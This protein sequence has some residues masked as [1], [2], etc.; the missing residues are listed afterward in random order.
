MVKIIATSE[1]ATFLD[2]GYY[3]SR[4]GEFF[5]LR[6]SN[7]V[8]EY[9]GLL[10]A[11]DSDILGDWTPVSLSASEFR[12]AK[13]GA[14]YQYT[15]VVSG[16]G[17]APV[18]SLDDLIT[19]FESGLAS[20]TLSQISITGSKAALFVGDTVI[21][22][23]EFLTMDITPTGY[24]LT[25]GAQVIAVV[26]S[27]PTSL[28]QFSNLASIVDR[29]DVFWA[30]SNAE[31]NQIISDLSAYGVEEL[32][33]TSNGNELLSIAGSASE[34]SVTLMG[35]KIALKG[36]F[37]S[38]FGAA[39]PLI[40][41]I[42][43]FLDFGTPV[44]FSNMSGF[45]FDRLVITNLDGDVIL[46]T[47][48][49]LGNSDTLTLDLL[50]ID[51]V[52]VNQSLLQIGDN[53][54]NDRY[55]ANAPWLYELG[56]SLTG[57]GGRDHLF[58]LGGHDT[59]SGGNGKDYLFGGSGVDWLD[60]G[61]GDDVLNPGDNNQ[62]YDLV[63]GSKG[64]DT[65]IY[66]DNEKGY[67][68]LSY[69]ALNAGITASI[70]GVANIGTV[71]KGANGTDTIIDVVKPT[72]AWGFGI[73][74]TEYNDVFN[75]VGSNAA[76]EWDS[77]TGVRG[78]RGVD[79]YNLTLTNG[80]VVRVEFWDAATGINV[81]IGKGRIL[82]D[83]FGNAE[84]LNLVQNGG[85]LEIQATRFSD[86]LIGSSAD[87]RFILREGNDFANGGG[88]DDL[89]RYDRFGVDA[90]NVNLGTGTATGIWGGTAF[91]HTLKNFEDIR[92]SR[93]AND[94]LTG[95]KQGNEIDGRG[96]NDKLFGKA[97]RDILLG[98]DGNDMLKGG[99]YSDT[100]D[101]GTGDDLLYGGKGPDVF[102]FDAQVD[103]GVDSIFDFRNN[104]DVIRI[105]D[106]VFADL[107]ITGAGA[108]TLVAWETGQV[109]LEGVNSSL[110]EITDFD[111]V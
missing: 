99:S 14:G 65:V 94:K 67:Q 85:K 62:H 42:Q 86:R 48:G 63:I 101:G 82:N 57:T 89:I 72:Q 55:D 25:S 46:K 18:S 109:T 98:K 13:S 45:S 24:T 77:W 32:S 16:S 81:N 51:G 61:N 8:L 91:T 38:D 75:I 107:T 11:V 39:L 83:G 71:N 66:S 30:L 54:S 59:L 17:I 12:F 73:T 49:V 20:G 34:V 60:G 56:D 5:D 33:L 69:S 3:E 92:G 95:N 4:L 111:F 93:D 88:G 87:E 19:A 103:S 79:E 21:P 26:G 1:I 68:E 44:D 52:A 9:Q 90:V 100:L 7:P 36:S 37:P 76:P 10:N 29:L 74:G 78:G 27:V 70:D 31:K 110:I 104:S 53:T 80:S 22:T 105:S 41:D 106:A 50:R 15:M 28:E 84:A 47:K 6:D 97:G 2:E 58:G 102:V 35:Y 40:F 23:A 43:D 96:G 108:N 64:N